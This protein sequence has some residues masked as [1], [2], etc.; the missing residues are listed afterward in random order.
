[1]K[2][3]HKKEELSL[4]ENSSDGNGLANRGEQK[5]QNNLV[6]LRS[7]GGAW[8]EIAV[9]VGGGGRRAW[10]EERASGRDRW[11]GQAARRVYR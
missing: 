8:V 5:G 9:S 11:S 3:P 10:T 1:M 6:T 4:A 2:E 7:W